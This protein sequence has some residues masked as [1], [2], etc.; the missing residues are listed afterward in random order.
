MSVSAWDLETRT[1]FSHLHNCLS[2]FLNGSIWME[3]WVGVTMIVFSAHSHARLPE[4]DPQCSTAQNSSWWCEETRHWGVTFSWSHLSSLFVQHS[5]SSLMYKSMY[6]ILVYLFDTR[7]KGFAVIVVIPY[8]HCQVTYTLL[9][10]YS[11]ATDSSTFIIDC[12]TE[13]YPGMG[14]GQK[15]WPALEQRRSNG[16][17]VCP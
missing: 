4:S 1:K 3:S 9:P 7:I 6:L 11:N 13:V 16:V 10:Y 15:L 2:A 14:M 12:M 17:C 8:M 5:I